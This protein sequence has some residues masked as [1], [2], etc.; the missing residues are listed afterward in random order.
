[1]TEVES[2]YDDE[3]MR[4]FYEKL[5]ELKAIVPAVYFEDGAVTAMMAKS[6]ADDGAAERG[7]AADAEAA[8]AVAV[9]AVKKFITEEEIVVEDLEDV[10]GA[11]ADD[12]E[13]LVAPT[14]VVD[15]DGETD[16]APSEATKIE[17]LLARL[18]ECTN[19]QR[20]D[21]WAVEFCYMNSKRN[22]SR[23]LNALYRCNRNQLE[24]VPYYARLTATLTVCMPE[25]GGKLTDLLTD[26][27]RYLNKKKNQIN[28][29]GKIKNVRFISELTKFRICPFA[30]T[31]KVLSKCVQ[32]FKP[33]SLEQ[34]AHVL[35]CCGRF[36]NLTPTTHPHLTKLIDILGR[37]KRNMKLDLALVRLA[38]SVHSRRVLGRVLHGHTC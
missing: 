31:F 18:P 10:D 26:E 35:E 3:E 30:Q 23:L 24:C 4:Q 16:E 37:K 12:D 27:F 33:H 28:L 15:E 36:L 38:P 17:A 19:R 21:D 7:E 5:K 9:A 8:A 6:E 25:F 32:D 34:L 13:D 20:I 1:M 11:G 29:E 14:G 22:R 2:P